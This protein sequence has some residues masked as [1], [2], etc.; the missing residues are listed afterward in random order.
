M[1][2]TYQFYG[3]PDYKTEKNLFK[4]LGNCG[5]LH[6]RALEQRIKYHGCASKSI[7][8]NEQV[9]EFAPLG[10]SLGL[11]LFM[12]K[13]ILTK[14]EL[15]WNNF[16]KKT[17]FK[18]PPIVFPSVTRQHNWISISKESYDIKGKNLFLEGLGK[19]KLFISRAIPD[20]VKALNI[21]YSQSGKWFVAFV[22]E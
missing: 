1:D 8:Y 15:E 2:K 10:E 22:C 6:T 17:R 13:K 4:L 16:L 21:K 7:I 5:I 11:S 18:K 9:N 19:I 12:V 20:T 3:V 14:V